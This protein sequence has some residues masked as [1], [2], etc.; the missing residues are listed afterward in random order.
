M[1]MDCK[2]KKIGQFFQVH[3]VYF[4]KVAKTDY[5]KFCLGEIP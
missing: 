4:A 3:L 2:L 1:K 5:S